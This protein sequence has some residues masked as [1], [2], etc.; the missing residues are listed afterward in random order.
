[1]VIGLSGVFYKYHIANR[2]K[3]DTVRNR[4]V[5]EWAEEIRKLGGGEFP[6]TYVDGP[7]SLQFYL[8]TK[9]SFVSV[10]EAV[11]LLRSPAAAFVV[12]KDV[13]AL[14]REMGADA[15]KLTEIKSWKG[16][17]DQFSLVGNRPTLQWE[18]QMVCVV[19]PVKLELE[20][21]REMDV[22]G[23][24]FEFGSGSREGTVTISASGTNAPTPIEGINGLDVKTQ[25]ASSSMKVSGKAGFRLAISEYS[26]AEIR[27]RKQR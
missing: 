22:S 18:D 19:E 9:R 1:V 14:R 7:V 2:K 24:K 4:V 17:R 3:E 21:V 12:T 11:E 5:R 26:A 25:G 15:S 8:R 6:L 23:L 10:E 20:R 13:L 27:T 16:R